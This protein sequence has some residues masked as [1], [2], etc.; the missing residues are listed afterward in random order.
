MGRKM[1]GVIFHGLHIV[2]S[3][4]RSQ[5]LEVKFSLSKPA[6]QVICKLIP[7]IGALLTVMEATTYG[8]ATI[9]DKS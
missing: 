2:D 6:S 1:S 4:G 7:G 9:G 8:T 3:L 5:P